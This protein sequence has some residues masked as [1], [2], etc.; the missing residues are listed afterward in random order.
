MKLVIGL[1]NPG[2]KYQNTRHNA[3]F[4]ALDLLAKEINL[5]FKKQDKF[6]SEIVETAN[7]E[8]EKILLA[9]PTTFMNN[10]GKAIRTITDFY[11]IENENILVI[12]DEIDLRLGT[13]KQSHDS[14]SAGHKGVESIIQTI[15]KD[16]SRYRIG[17][18]N[19]SSHED[20]QTDQYVLEPF[21]PEEEKVVKDVLGK[22]GGRIE[23]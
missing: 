2:K 5:Q 13:F 1:G 15:G 16:F 12:H 9:K 11:K 4:L 17:V 19:R 21:T 20:A 23:H 22:P 18:D 7:A 6:F 3:G 8:N 14:G 10:S